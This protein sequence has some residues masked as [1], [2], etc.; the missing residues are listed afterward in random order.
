MKFQ[1]RFTAGLLL[2]C[3]LGA[4]QLR[5][6]TTSVPTATQYQSY[7]TTLAAT[8]GTQPYTWS[9]VSSTGTSLPEGM[10]LSA[11][12]WCSEFAAG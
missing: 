4:A 6:T 12:S 5:I 7:T 1:C 11:A 8:G 10:S 3:A 9:V 2:F